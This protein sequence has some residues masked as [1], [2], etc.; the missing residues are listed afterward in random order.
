MIHMQLQQ[1]R[2]SSCITRCFPRGSICGNMANI[3]TRT[4][5]LIPSTY[6]IP[7]PQ[8]YLCV[9]MK[10]CARLSHVQGQEPTATF[11]AVH[12]SSAT[13]S[14]LLPTPT[15]PPPTITNLC[16]IPTV[17]SSQRCSINGST[18]DVTSGD[19]LFSLNITGWRSTRG[20]VGIS[21]MCLVLFFYC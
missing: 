3:T 6:L 17:P 10:F 9:C 15:L 20:A 18:H 4:S 8:F 11:R 1:I 21:S 12:V 7:L 14:P 16:S 2:E 13:R 19:W 5:T